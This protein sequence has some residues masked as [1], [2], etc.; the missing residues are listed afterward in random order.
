MKNISGALYQTFKQC[1]PID[2]GRHFSVGP[3]LGSNCLKKLLA[4]THGVKL[5][6]FGIHIIK[7]TRKTM[8]N[9]CVLK[10]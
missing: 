9:S 8:K 1:V 5:L 4:D 7:N 3:D 10:Y 6:K 2:Q